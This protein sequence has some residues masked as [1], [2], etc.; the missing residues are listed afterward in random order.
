MNTIWRLHSMFS[1]CYSCNTF[2]GFCC[3]HIIL[4]RFRVRLNNIFTHTAT[5]RH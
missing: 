1:S 4:Q 2:I 5:W 3:C